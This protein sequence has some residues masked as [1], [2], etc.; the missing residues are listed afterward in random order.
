MLFVGQVS[1]HLRQILQKSS[2]PMSI[3]LS[4]HQRQVGQDRVGH[5]DPGAELLA[6][7]HAVAASSPSPAASPAACGFTAP[8][9]RRVAQLADVALDALQ[10][11][12]PRSSAR[13][14]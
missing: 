7:H 8:R 13:M 12:A 9:M 2:T 3:G 5:V 14:W 6:D 4:G 1:A 10:D 11:H